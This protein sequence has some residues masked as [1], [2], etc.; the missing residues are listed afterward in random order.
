MTSQTSVKRTSVT[1]T[2]WPP[3]G[4]GSHGRTI[5][6]FGSCDEAR[7]YIHDTWGDHGSFSD[8][9]GVEGWNLGPE[10]GCAVATIESVE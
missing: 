1:V 4:H 6:G 7:A 10:D 2:V 8:D 5:D 3:D 9:E